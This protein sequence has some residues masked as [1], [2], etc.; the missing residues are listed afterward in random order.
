[1]SAMSVRSGPHPTP[2]VERLL[3]A[4]RPLAGE[5]EHEAVVA[6]ARERVD[7]ERERLAAG[8]RRRDRSEEL[9]ER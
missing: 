4:A 9:A 8:T 2:S 6:A 1:M 7:E 3:A 5:R